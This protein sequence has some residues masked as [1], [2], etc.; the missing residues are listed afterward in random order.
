MMSKKMNG[1]IGAVVLG[2]MLISSTVSAQESRTP[3]NNGAAS[4]SP[5]TTTADD[6]YRS[7]T[8]DHRFDLGWI[9]LAGVLG[10]AGLL[11]KDR[12]NHRVQTGTAAHRQS[13]T[14]A[15]QVDVD[16]EGRFGLERNGLF[17]PILDELGH[18]ESAQM[19]KN[20]LENE[21]RLPPQQQDKP[22]IESQNTLLA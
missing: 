9:G 21:P 22:G 4:T 12:D 10:L 19:K 1:K 11:R 17:L 7:R 16:S 13:E 15:R 5:T 6:T 2:L 20:M 8:D 3:G 18:N 14:C